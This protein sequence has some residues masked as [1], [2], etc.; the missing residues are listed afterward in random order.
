MSFSTGSKYL[1][2]GNASVVVD[3]CGRQ[4]VHGTHEPQYKS[5]FFKAEE[6]LL[7]SYIQPFVGP[8][9]SCCG[10]NDTVGAP[11]L[12]GLLRLAQTRVKERE[13]EPQNFKLPQ[14]SCDWTP[15][16]GTQAELCTKECGRGFC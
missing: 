12:T 2:A 9:P 11:V 3:R 16:A 10:T 14:A 6:L 4:P 13:E 7:C 5:H 1:R 15:A 8:T